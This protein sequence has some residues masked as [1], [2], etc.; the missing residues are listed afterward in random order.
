MRAGAR[1]EKT[2]KKNHFRAD[3]GRVSCLPADDARENQKQQKPVK[4]EA[5]RLRSRV[6]RRRN[7]IKAKAGHG[8]TETTRDRG[9]NL[10]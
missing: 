1:L 2:K 8:Q 3:Q 9:K 6:V 4:K 10:N 7:H 5:D